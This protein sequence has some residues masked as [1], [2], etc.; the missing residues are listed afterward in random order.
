MSPT[1]QDLSN[2]TTFSQIKSRVPVPL[3]YLLLFPF[4]KNDNNVH[5]P[6]YLYSLRSSR[7][8]HI[9]LFIYIYTMYACT[10]IR[11]KWN[12]YFQ[13]A[14]RLFLARHGG[15][16]CGRFGQ[17]TDST[18]QRGESCVSR[19]ISGTRIL[20]WIRL[21]GISAGWKTGILAIETYIYSK[22]WIF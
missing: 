16:P 12:L 5:T 19:M 2:D 15:S 18:V 22:V 17:N 9:T 4:T 8:P 6:T 13:S 20:S 21:W 3:T 11:C 7:F 14:I 1:H 10:Y